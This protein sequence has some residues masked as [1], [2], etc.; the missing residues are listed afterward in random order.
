MNSLVSIIVPTYNSDRY[1]KKCL[2]SIRNQ[3]YKHIEVIVVD[4]SSTDSSLEVVER[5]KT[6]LIKLPPPKFYTPPTV[7]RNSGA[8]I[9]KGEI[10]IHIDSDMILNKNLVEEIVNKF[11]KNV[12]VGALV[13]HEKD[14]TKGFWSKCKAFERRCY[15]GNLKIESA[16]AVRTEIFN[17]V[18]GYDESLSTGEDFDIH[19]RYMQKCQVEFCKNVLYHDLGRL[20]FSLMIKKKYNY[21]KTASKYFNKHGVSGQDLLIEQYKCFVRNYKMFVKSPII[22]CGALFLKMAEFGAGGLGALINKTR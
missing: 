13:I 14:I 5:F 1:I 12:K 15:W 3:S 2:D 21:G 22:G 20:R 6:K 17:E 18:K 4:Q 7:S 16:R 10:L 11:Q 8:K 19:M 9:A